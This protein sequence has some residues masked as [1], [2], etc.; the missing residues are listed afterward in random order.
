MSPKHEKDRSHSPSVP[1]ASGDEPN[2]G[3]QKAKF[4][5]CSPRERG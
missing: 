5:S 3:D 4:I 2:L 1:R